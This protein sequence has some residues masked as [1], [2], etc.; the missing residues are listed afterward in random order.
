MTLTN[1]EKTNM[2]P[3]KARPGQIYIKKFYTFDKVSK[4]APESPSLLHVQQ[5]LLDIIYPFLDDSELSVKNI[6]Y[7]WC[8]QTPETIAQAWKDP[9]AHGDVHILSSNIE[10]AHIAVLK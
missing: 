1:M 2:H 4:D 8:L 7:S 3:V 6:N 5:W 9:R 10:W